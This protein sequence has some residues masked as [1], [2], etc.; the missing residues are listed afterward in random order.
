MLF[1]SCSSLC[2]QI[3]VF[4]GLLL[5]YA[6]MRISEVTIG[7]SYQNEY[8]DVDFIS[9]SGNDLQNLHGAYHHLGG[10]IGVQRYKVEKGGL[11]RVYS[12]NMKKSRDEVTRST[13]VTDHAGGTRIVDFDV[14][15][16]EYG[17]AMDRNTQYS[18]RLY[19][20]GQYFGRDTKIKRPEATSYGKLQD[21]HEL[22][23]PYM[24]VNVR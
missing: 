8:V 3:S 24:V 11:R 22:G 15:S 13:V 23:P 6:E 20:G 5:K 2:I 17:Y 1:R 21:D 16:N 19:P 12:K 7:R 18:F 14:W 4:A 9:V 10:E